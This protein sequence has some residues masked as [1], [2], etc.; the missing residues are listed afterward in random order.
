MGLLV[1][2]AY[3]MM[4]LCLYISVNSN[5]VDSPRQPPVITSKRLPGGSGFDVWKLSG[6]QKFDKGGDFV[7]MESETFCPSI[8]FI[9]DK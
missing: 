5:W 2:L 1:R 8:G 4:L 9:S 3:F 6:G 7:E